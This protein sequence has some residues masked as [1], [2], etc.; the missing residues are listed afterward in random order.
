ML[1]RIRFTY[2]KTTPLRYT[3]HLDLQRVWERT[4]RRSRLPVAFSQGFSPTARFHMACALPLGFTSRCE[5][6]DLWLSDSMPLPEVMAAL[7]PCIPPGIEIHSFEEV[8][9]KAPAL[10]TIVRSSNYQILL[11]D[12]PGFEEMQ[13]RIAVLL[14]AAQL[15]R[16][17]REKNYDLRPLVEALE[18]T[19]TDGNGR[20]I[21]HAQ[22]ATRENATGRPE[23]LLSALGLDPLA[24]RVERM[25]IIF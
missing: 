24:A 21:L 1:Q 4:L 14:G 22:L 19:G 3:G 10:Q 6:L 11:L 12:S 25:A 20:F 9:L 13:T 5:I 23:E 2:A 18:I 7:Q 16:V 15:P 8:D 17:W